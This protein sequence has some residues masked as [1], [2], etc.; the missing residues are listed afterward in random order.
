MSTVQSFSGVVKT[1][2]TGNQRKHLR[3]VQASKRGISES[4]LLSQRRA[5]MEEWQNEKTHL[6]SSRCPN[7]GAFGHSFKFCPFANDVPFR[8]QNV[9]RF[10]GPTGSWG[11]EPPLVLSLK[12]QQRSNQYFRFLSMPLGPIKQAKPQMPPTRRTNN[13]EEEKDE[14][15]SLKKLEDVHIRS[16]TES[17]NHFLQFSIMD[18]QE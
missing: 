3:F 11:C 16:A 14:K 5:M 7:C 15:N 12:E 1:R 2:L 18:R 17:G 4:E 9:T 6:S 10:R 8:L 13:T